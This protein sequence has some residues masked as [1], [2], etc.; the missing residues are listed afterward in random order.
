MTEPSFPTMLVVGDDGSLGVIVESLNCF[1]V[2]SYSQ[3]K[4]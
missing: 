4:G 2:N 1:E 3:S